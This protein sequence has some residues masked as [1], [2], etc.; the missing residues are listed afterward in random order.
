MLHGRSNRVEDSRAWAPLPTPNASQSPAISPHSGHGA[1]P[2]LQI[3]FAPFAFFAAKIIPTPSTSKFYTIYTF[4]TVTNSTH[5]PINL[6]FLHDLHVLHG[7]QPYP[8]PLCL[9][10]LMFIPARNIGG[11]LHISSKD[12]PLKKTFLDLSVGFL[13]KNAP[14]FRSSSCRSILAASRFTS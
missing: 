6:Q 3:I 7:Y 13:A 12:K 9:Q 5:S 8:L 2:H 10:I 11:W 1:E 4:Y 14:L